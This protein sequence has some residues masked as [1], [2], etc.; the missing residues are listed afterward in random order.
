MEIYDVNPTDAS[1]VLSA[2]LLA[3][4]CGMLI[5]GVIADRTP[6]HHW[7]AAVGLVTAAVLM[8]LLAA[9]HP[10]FWTAAALMAAAGLAVGMTGPSRDMLIK[11]AT[12]PGSTGKVFGFVYSGLDLGAL[13]GPMIFGLLMDWHMPFHIFT[14]VMILQILG[15]F[16]AFKVRQASVAMRAA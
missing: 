7:V 3:S 15:V 11:A 1:N 6:Q 4:A 5:G 2:Y 10:E 8:V 14:A 9:G 12:P 13:A 16:T